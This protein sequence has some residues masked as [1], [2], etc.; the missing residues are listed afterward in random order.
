M[1]F[2][3]K[4]AAVALLVGLSASVY[5]GKDNSDR[6]AMWL[7]FSALSAADGKLAS[8]VLA[9]QGMYLAECSKEILDPVSIRNHKEFTTFQY[10]MTNPTWDGIERMKKRL[11]EK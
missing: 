2:L 7:S 8:D 5:A 3:K 10:A 4:I 6:V 11:C 9:F 1:R